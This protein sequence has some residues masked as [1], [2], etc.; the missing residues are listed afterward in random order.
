VIT[1]TDTVLTGMLVSAAAVAAGTMPSSEALTPGQPSRDAE[2][3]HASH[4]ALLAPFAGARS[5]ELLLVVD[6]E[7]STALRNAAAGPVDLGAALTPT[8]EAM[9][10][11]IGPVTLGPVQVTEARLTVNRILAASESALIPLLGAAGPRA[12]VAIALTPAATEAPGVLSAPPADRL[13]LLRGV[14]MDATAELG[15]T[16]MT[17]N[18]L[19]ALRSGAVVELDRVAGGPADLLVNGRL[20]ARGE[21]V[22][23]DENYGIR[24]TQVITDASGR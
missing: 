7:L 2:M 10:A 14:E 23:V 11:A 17:V 24:I 16:R 21:V 6:E 1:E 9:A 18:D 12:A 22:V 3:M 8:V 4:Q 19:L 13:D 5:G 15:R 20:I